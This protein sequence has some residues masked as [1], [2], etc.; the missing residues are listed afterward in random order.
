MSTMT[1]NET[2]NC[3]S[4]AYVYKQ[5]CQTPLESQW[6]N[7]V[8]ILL[9]SEYWQS[10]TLNTL[11][12]FLS[13]FYTVVWLMKHCTI[14]GFLVKFALTFRANVYLLLNL[15]SA[16]HYSGRYTKFFSFSCPVPGRIMYSRH[17][18][19]ILHSKTHIVSL[20]ICSLLIRSEHC[21][22][23]DKNFRYATSYIP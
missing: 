3:N 1:P 7:S 19:C 2:N 16:A 6:F 13:I 8:T 14:L 21:E 9:S 12:V 11:F 20:D 18:G 22:I 4:I 5:C 15:S 17:L 23:C 10:C